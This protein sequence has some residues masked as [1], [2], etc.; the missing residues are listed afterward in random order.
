M[1]KQSKTAKTRPF[2]QKAM[3]KVKGKLIIIEERCKGCGFC[4]EF[5]P[6]GVLYVSDRFNKSGY[7]PPEIDETKDCVMC[8]LCE[9]ICPEFAIYNEEESKGFIDEGEEEHKLNKEAKN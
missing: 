4:V 9:L 2:N 8:R 1:R 5:C 3:Q 6:K 7:H